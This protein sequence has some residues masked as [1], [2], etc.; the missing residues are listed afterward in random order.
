MCFCS[1]LLT[2]AAP[3]WRDLVSDIGVPH[4]TR[5]TGCLY[6]YDTPAAYRAA[7]ADMTTRRTMGVTADL[8]S[9][10]ALH[11]L[12]PGL[13]PMAGAAFFPNAMTLTDPGAVMDALAA[14]LTAIPHIQ[15][16]VDALERTP[17]GIRLSGP[18]ITAKRVIIAAGVV[19]NRP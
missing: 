5:H 7:H 16:R 3:L 6:L 10:D 19:I 11:A 2:D 1:F 8:L 13:P 12:E 14:H 4:L 9:S 15:A 18:N 17:Q